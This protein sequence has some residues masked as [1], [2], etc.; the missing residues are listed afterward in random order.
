M[1]SLILILLVMVSSGGAYVIFKILDVLHANKKLLEEK[2]SQHGIPYVLESEH[3]PTPF[4]NEQL[5]DT[6]LVISN[7]TPMI[8]KKVDQP[9]NRIG[10]STLNSNQVQ[11][12]SSSIQD[13]AVAGDSLIGSTKI[14]NQTVNDAD[15]IARAAAAA[16]IDAYRM[17]LDDRER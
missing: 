4:L 2:N 13:S 6:A 9:S 8:G 3:E 7:K 16:A 5:S 11:S 10:H 12:L 15:A 1:D 14:E 17:G